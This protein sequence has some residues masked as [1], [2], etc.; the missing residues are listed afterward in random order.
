VF[1]NIIDW[2]LQELN[3]RFNEVTSD[4]FHGVACLNPVDSFPNFD[5]KKIVRM[6][7]L[8]PYDFDEFNLGILEN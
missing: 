8:Y 2:Q 1:Y 4:L 7:K 3:G 6:A 5:I